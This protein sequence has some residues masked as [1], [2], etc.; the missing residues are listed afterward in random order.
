MSEAASVMSRSQER[1]DTAVRRSRVTTSVLAAFAVGGVIAFG[2]GAFG[3]APLRAWQTYLVNL[4]FFMGIAQAGAVFLAILTLTQSRWGRPLERFAAA[5]TAFLPVAFLLFLLLP[6][7]QVVIFPWVREPIPEKSLWLNFTFLMAR[8]GVGLALLFSLSAGLV[9]QYVRP[10]AGTLRH[11]TGDWRERVYALLAYRFRGLETEIARCRGRTPALA[12]GL[13]AVYWFVFSMIAGDLIMSLDPHWYSTLLGAYN[14]V[15]ALYT[16]LAALAVL[17]LWGRSRFA[18]ERSLTVDHLH[19]MGKMIFA[20]ALI[21]G[22]FFWSQ[23]LVIWYGNLPEETS[24]IARRIHHQPWTALSWTVLVG[25]FAMPFVLLLARAPKRNPRALAAICGLILITGWAERYLLIVP[26][27]TAA[28]DAAF[29]LLEVFITLGFVAAF[30]I[31]YRLF[32]TAFPPTVA[33]PVAS[34]SPAGAAQ[35]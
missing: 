4:L 9:Y 32:L 21:A 34:T 33:A 15:I 13:V 14:F 1:G 27:L 8:D 31:C 22:D 6:F 24:F 17:A 10:L 12:L 20:F 30:L 26:S 16:G 23:F 7:G 28:E 18:L 2:A 29:G 11:T 35:G 25:L 5:M 19:D 3:A